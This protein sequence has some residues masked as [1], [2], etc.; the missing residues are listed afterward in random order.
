MP[1][2]ELFSAYL[3]YYEYLGD[4]FWHTY[5]IMWRIQQYLEEQLAK[6]TR[7]L[8]VHSDLTNQK[9]FAEYLCHL[10]YYLRNMYATDDGYGALKILYDDPEFDPD[11]SLPDK[12][13]YDVV[14]MGLRFNGGGLCCGWD[15]IEV[16]NQWN[17]LSSDQRRNLRQQSN[18]QK[19][20]EPYLVV[21]TGYTAQDYLMRE[22]QSLGGVNDFY[23]LPVQISDFE[24]M[25]NRY[26]Q[27]RPINLVKNTR[28]KNS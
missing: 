20:R 1:S 7:F 26:H 28:V 13:V 16:C 22:C 2:P 4:Q 15:F 19:D 23:S 14:L 12:P 8:I 21:L 10:G 5:P 11:T 24:D 27:T 6:E 18:L 3:D 17:T 25:L 9:V